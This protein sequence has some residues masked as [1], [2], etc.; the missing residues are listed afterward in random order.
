MQQ[1]RIYLDNAAT[2]P[3]AKEVAEAMMPYITEQFGNPSSTHYYGRVARLA[4]ENARKQVAQRLGA[5]ASEI[6]FTSGGT[7]SNNTA[8][9][10][11]IFGLGCRHIISSPLEHHAILHTVEHYARRRHATLSHVALLADGHIDLSDLERQL[12]QCPVRCL[13]TLMHANSETGNITDI[14]AVGELCK[15][16]DAI[17]H[18]DCVQ[19]V[20][21]YPIDL[22][23]LYIHF[24]SASAHKFHGPKGT[25]ILFMRSDLPTHALIYGGGQEREMRSGTEN[26]TGI[27]GFSTALS[28]ALDHYK[29][30]S[31]T[32]GRL[33][34]Y[35]ILRLKELGDVISFN[36]DC[37]GNSLYTV[38]NVS[39]ARN[40][41]T[42]GLLFAL[43]SK[44]ICV[45]G[46]SAC[47]AG[48]SS[49]SHVIKAMRRETAGI[50]I[51]FSFS[52]YNTIAEIDQ[53]MVVLAELIEER[54]RA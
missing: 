4:V 31:L 48:S 42:E 18:S 3:V 37:E 45:S 47:S 28:L 26:V 6:Y 20:G 9:H 36:G 2:T 25:G 46:G 7:E 15:K 50:P 1:Q 5:K 51:R 35:F 54:Q 24:I 10:A 30:D 16:Y 43:D 32:V 41:E 17:F 27:V 12:Q 40:E 39:F 53:L 21:H 33:K 52:R 23:E 22:V 8:I 38:V 34:K 11:A 29:E 13:V 49:V 19:T 44:G 14:K